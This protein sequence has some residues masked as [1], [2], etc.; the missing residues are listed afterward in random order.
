MENSKKKYLLKFFTVVGCPMLQFYKT[1]NWIISP[2]DLPIIE[3]LHN[4]K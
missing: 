2:K 3:I 4:K 1:L